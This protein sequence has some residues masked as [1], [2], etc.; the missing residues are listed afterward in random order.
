MDRE[1]LQKEIADLTERYRAAGYFPAACVRVFSA[2]ETLASVCVGEAEEHSLFDVASLTKIA[3]ATQIL[4]LAD[5]GKIALDGDIEGY[6]PAVKESAF[7][8]PLWAAVFNPFLLQGMAGGEKG[9]CA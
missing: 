5:E 4:F 7:F 6:L 1:R 9:D 2:E 8:V 3:T